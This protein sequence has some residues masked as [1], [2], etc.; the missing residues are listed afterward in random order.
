[1]SLDSHDHED[2]FSVAFDPCLE[3]STFVVS[4]GHSFG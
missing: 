4:A 3:E 2:L 1:M